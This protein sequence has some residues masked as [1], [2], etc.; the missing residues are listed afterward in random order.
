MKY[1]L[2]GKGDI[3]MTFT[4]YAAAV[5]FVLGL[6]ID[7]IRF[8]LFAKIH[9]KFVFRVENEKEKDPTYCTEDQYYGIAGAGIVYICGSDKTVFL[10]KRSD[11][12][13]GG[14]G[15]WSSIGGGILPSDVGKKGQDYQKTPIPDDLRLDP[16]AQE[17]MFLS[18]A[19]KEVIEEI[20]FLPEAAWRDSHVYEDC[21]FVY[22]VHVMEVSEAEKEKFT[23]VK[24]NWESSGHKWLGLDEFIINAKKRKVFLDPGVVAIIK[25]L[26]T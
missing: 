10:Q 20:G 8:R 9:V 7:N 18:H 2:P 11:S 25:R 14:A 21:G 23:K 3:S 15:M 13:S 12:V 24:S 6:E 16:S 19:K 1:Y 4:D 26:L 22:K 5:R 17:A